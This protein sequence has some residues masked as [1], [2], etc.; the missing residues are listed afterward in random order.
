[1]ASH[2]VIHNAAGGY[3]FLGREGRPFSNGVLADHGLDLVHATFE[4]PQPLH[5]G[6][7]A[8]ARHVASAGRPAQSL[9]G[10]EL[11]IKRPLTQHQFDEFNHG[12]IAMLRGI[13]LEVD[14]LMPATRTNVAPVVGSVEEPSLFA[15]TYTAPGSRGRPAFILSGVPEEIEGDDRSMLR[16]ITEIL[17]ARATVLGCSLGDATAIQLYAGGAIDPEA[18]ADVAAELGDAA[19]HGLH[20]FPSLPPIEGLRFE[21]DARAAGTE[22]ILTA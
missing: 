19:L 2:S 12:Y 5:A 11:R 8:A 13:G 10:F 4:R 1:M 21:I 7:A 17:T 18:I 14:D 20:W 16:N 9:A 3:R 6:V 15:F 22:L